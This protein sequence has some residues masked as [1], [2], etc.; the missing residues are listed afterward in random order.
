MATDALLH[1][2][3]RASILST[4]SNVADNKERGKEQQG[5]AR[6]DTIDNPLTS[7]TKRGHIVLDKD[8]FRDRKVCMHS[9]R[10]FEI[11]R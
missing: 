8:I 9:L 10:D 4:N 1:K 7:A 2:D 3:C 6:G 5:A 11:R